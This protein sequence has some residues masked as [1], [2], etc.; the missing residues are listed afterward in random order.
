MPQAEPELTAKFEHD[1]EAMA[2]LLAAGWKEVANG[3]MRPPQGMSFPMP[4]GR[5][6]DAIDYLCDEWDFD[7]SHTQFNPT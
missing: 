2:V 3:M 4:P 5:E 1:G 7:I 6:A